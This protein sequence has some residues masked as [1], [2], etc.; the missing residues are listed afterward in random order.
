MRKKFKASLASLCL[1]AL[2]GLPAWALEPAAQ[3]T[4]RGIDV[5][6][7]QGEIDFAR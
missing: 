4:E 1:L 6:A 3:P 5:S 7:W 2:L